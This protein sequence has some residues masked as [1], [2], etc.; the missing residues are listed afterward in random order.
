MKIT[1]RS[2]SERRP[3]R[4]QTILQRGDERD[5]ALFESGA[6]LSS[7]WSAPRS[8]RVLPPAR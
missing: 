4:L 8:R 1:A 3:P 2:A 5:T 6:A 7:G